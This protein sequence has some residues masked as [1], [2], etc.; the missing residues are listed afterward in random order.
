MLLKVPVPVRFCVKKDAENVPEVS[1][2]L[3]EFAIWGPVWMLLSEICPDFGV[4]AALKMLLW[5]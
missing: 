1:G 5:Y 2:L 4:Y 3:P